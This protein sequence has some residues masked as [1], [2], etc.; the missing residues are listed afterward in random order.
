MSEFSSV[1]SNLKKIRIKSGDF[2][3]GGGEV[4]DG[5]RKSSYNVVIYGNSEIYF[6]FCG[7]VVN[8]VMKLF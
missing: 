1:L 5:E 2:F 7:N 3:W 8:D 6:S 4:V